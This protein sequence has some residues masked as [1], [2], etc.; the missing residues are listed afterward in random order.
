MRLAQDMGF[1]EDLAEIQ[2]RY[3]DTVLPNSA[4]RETL[5]EIYFIHYNGLGPEKVEKAWLIP[6]PDGYI[7]KI[8]YPQFEE[9]SYQISYG[10]ITL[11]GVGSDWFYRFPTVLMQDLGTIAVTNLENRINRIKA[12]AI[13]RATAKYLGVLG[14]A[15]AAEDGENERF[16]I[17]VRVLGNILAAATEQADLRHWRLLPAE[18]RVGR[19]VVPPGRYRGEID[20]VDACGAVV[21]SRPIQPF[22]VAS[23]ETRFFIHRTLQ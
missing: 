14:A 13:A 10:E 2:H 19:A 12:K 8:A 16:G 15:K 22:M 7:A 21:S 17:L 1:Y 5:A 11:R 3:P 6:M 20:F 18:I 9:R 4:D 23:G